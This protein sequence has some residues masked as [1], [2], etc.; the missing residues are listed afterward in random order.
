[1]RDIR[2]AA[3]LLLMMGGLIFWSIFA[4]IGKKA[5][6][7]EGVSNRIVSTSWNASTDKKAERGVGVSNRNFS[8]SWNAS[9]SPAL[10]MHTRVLL[11]FATYPSQQHL[12]FMQECWP[13]LIQQPTLLC[14]TDVL[15]YLGGAVKPAFLEECRAA[16][17]QLPV[18]ATLRYQELN[19][20]YQKG[21]MRGM[22]EMLANGW[23][24]G[25]DWV[26]RLKPNVLIYDDAYMR[27]LMHPPGTRVS[28]V[29][30]NCLGSSASLAVYTDFLALR[31]S[32]LLANAFANWKT[33]PNA[34]RQATRAFASII[35]RKESAW[36]H[37]HNPRDSTCRIRGHGVWHDHGSCAAT[38]QKKPWQGTDPTAAIPGRKGAVSG[39]GLAC[40]HPSWRRLAFAGVHATRYI[41]SRHKVGRR[42]L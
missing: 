10:H 27:A 8:T 16:L 12:Q 36:I 7:G 35:G 30:A 19:P 23:G 24:Q 13:Q 34:E 38:L 2:I 42:V 31:P 39:A 32:A 41:C 28:A 1:M 26:I 37:Q 15:V 40:P 33:F 14:T 4:H 29:L 6:R 18:N 21:A 11:Y 20:G 5:E 3:A 9:A 22:H 17:R 25:Y